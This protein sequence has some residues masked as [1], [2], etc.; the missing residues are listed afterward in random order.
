M[1]K[2]LSVNLILSGL[3]L[4]GLMLLKAHVAEGWRTSSLI[5]TP[6]SCSTLGSE[7]SQESFEAVLAERLLRCNRW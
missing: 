4:L 1:S 3:N 5:L 2:G 7:C 6:S